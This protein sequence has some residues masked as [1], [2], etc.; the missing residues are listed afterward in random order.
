MTMEDLS[1][2]FTW[3]ADWAEGI[4]P[5]Y[6]RLTRETAEDQTLCDIASEAPSDQP[7]PQLFLAAVHALLL[8]GSEHR[9]AAFY[10]TCSDD[11]VDPAT[12]DPFP[13]FREFCLANEARIREIVSSRRV[14]TNAVGRSAILFPAFQHVV[15]AGAQPPLALVEIGASAGLNLYWDRFQYKYEGYGAYGNLDSPIQIESGV[16]GDIDPPLSHTIPDVGYRVGVDLDTLD[17]T[18]SADIHWLR[19]LVIPDQQWRHQR[20]EAAIKLVQ[21]DPPRLREGDAVD[22]LPELLPKVPDNLELCVFSTHILYQLNEEQLKN[23]GNILIKHSQE[24]PIH[25]L[26]NDPHAESNHMTY[27]YAALH[28]GVEEERQIAEHDSYGK[29]IRWLIAE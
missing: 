12:R 9:L 20:L 5:L 18:D 29:W 15:T 19:A 24:R 21:D 6:E 14:Q 16:Q 1:E 11:P 22:V 3:Y 25:W 26:S 23:L 2:A 7:P 10:P 27:R 13:A 28:K 8:R 17:V 4:S